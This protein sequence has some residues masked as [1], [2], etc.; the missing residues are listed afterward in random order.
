MPAVWYIGQA[1]K[2]TVGVAD[3]E[4]FGIINRPAVTW[5]QENGWSIPHSQLTEAQRALL[6]NDPLFVV[7]APDGARTGMPAGV[8]AGDIP[9]KGWTVEQI[10]QR[11]GE[12]G[13]VAD[14]E[15]GTAG[16]PEADVPV[17][18]S[19][20]QVLTK[21]GSEDFDTGWRTPAAGGGGG[22]GTADWPAGGTAGQYLGKKSATTGDVG[23][24][25]LPPAGI[26]TVMFANGDSSAPRPTTRTDIMVIFATTG[27]TP[28]ANMVAN[29]DLWIQR[30]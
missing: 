18:G 22:G 16:N 23:W 17:G 7:G 19:A 24:M 11:L 21:I 12:R 28:P 30:P 15:D 3:W 9:T 5:E 27:T 2:R 4:D 29:L 26:G 1:A 8:D 14:P 20:G 6:N 13:T 25:S 10:V